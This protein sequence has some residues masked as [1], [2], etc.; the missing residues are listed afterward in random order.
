MKLDGTVLGRFGKAG[1]RSRSS[2]A[3]TSWTAGFPNTIYTAEIQGW[4]TQK[5]LLKPDR[6]R[7]VRR[8]GTRREQ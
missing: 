3:S 2:P 8:A 4:R 6:M 1:R 5:V 7:D